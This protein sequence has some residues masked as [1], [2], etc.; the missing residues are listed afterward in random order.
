MQITKKH[1]YFLI[2]HKLKDI[3]ELILMSMELL[4]ELGMSNKLILITAIH[5]KIAVSQVFMVKI[6][7]Q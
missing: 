3:G 7:N 2:E 4:V 5:T 1:L 6:L